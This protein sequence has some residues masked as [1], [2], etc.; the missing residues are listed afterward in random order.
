M[1]DDSTAVG[2]LL[3]DVMDLDTALQSFSGVLVLQLTAADEPRLSEL[4]SVLEKHKGR[5]RIFLETTGRDGAA[6]RVRAGNQ[7]GVTLCA[8]LARDLESLLGRGKVRLARS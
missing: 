8:E 7:H 3:E 5:N 1:N 6:R 4:K 2:L